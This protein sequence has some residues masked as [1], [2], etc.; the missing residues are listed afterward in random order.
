M[1]KLKHIL[2]FYIDARFKRVEYSY[3]K[4]VYDPFE[5]FKPTKTFIKE[6]IKELKQQCYDLIEKQRNPEYDIIKPTLT[7]QHQQLLR[8]IND[9]DFRLKYPDGCAENGKRS[10]SPGDK[11]R[12]KAVPIQE[13]YGASVRRSGKRLYGRCPFHNDRTASFV[14]YLDQ[15][16]YHCYGCNENGDSISFVRKDKGLNFPQSI[17]YLINK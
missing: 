7:Q 8:R 16:T 15:N 6:K 12:A 9:Y 14:I 2:P 1:E 4:P 10:V 17:K 11:E 13:L 3:Q 5:V